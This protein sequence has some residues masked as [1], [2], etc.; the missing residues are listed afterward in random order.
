[1]S[2]GVEPVPSQAFVSPRKPLAEWPLE[3]RPGWAL[4]SQTSGFLLPTP[5]DKTEPGE[6]KDP[7]VVLQSD[8]VPAEEAHLG[9]NCY[10]DKAKSFFD[11][12]SSELKSRCARA[13]T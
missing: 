11:N 4:P 6:E 7:A 2:P 8:E 12:I 9:P 5:D 10:Y 1:M 3:D 13:W